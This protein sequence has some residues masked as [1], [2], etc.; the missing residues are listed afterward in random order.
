MTKSNKN[1]NKKNSTTT[2]TNTTTN[3]N[4]NKNT[5]KTRSRA[6][7]KRLK[8]YNIH[9]RRDSKGRILWEDFKS[10]STQHH[11][12]I[13]PDRRW[14]G[15]TRTITQND[16]QKFRDHLESALSGKERPVSNKKPAD[17]QPATPGLTVPRKEFLMIKGKIP[18]SLLHT[19]DHFPDAI[20]NSLLEIESFESTFGPK[21]TR[22]RPK[23][24]HTDLTSLVTDATRRSGISFFLTSHFFHPKE[25]D[26]SRSFVVSRAEEG[27]G[28]TLSLL[29]TLLLSLSLS[30]SLSLFLSIEE[31]KEEAD[32]NVKVELE[33]KRGPPT[34][35][36]ITAGQS[37]RI[38]QELHKVLDS[39]DVVVQVLDARDPLGTRS[40]WLERFLRV[41]YP[42]K[43]LILLLNKADLVPHS[44]TRAWLALLSQEYPT[45]AFHASLNK[46]FG[47][48]ALIQ[49][50]RQFQQLHS[51]KPQISVG[52][53]GYPNVG[54]S[55]VI[56]TLRHKKVC[57]VAP[58]PGETKVWQ[59]ITLFKRIFLID[60]PGVVTNVDLLHDATTSQRSEWELHASLVL[61]G[62]VRIENLTDPVSYI[63]ALL[64]RVKE[65]YLIN[66][67]EFTPQESERWHQ[68]IAQNP[69]E[70]HLTFLEIHARKT[71][72]LK[73]GGHADL[74]ASARM[75]LNDWLRGKIPYFVPPPSVP[76]VLTPLAGVPTSAPL[77]NSTVCIVA[78]FCV[79]FSRVLTS[80]LL[81][82]PFSSS[83]LISPPLTSSLL[84]LSS[85]HFISPHLTSSHFISPSLPSSLPYTVFSHLIAA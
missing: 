48:G 82:P 53:V 17:P 13:Q 60:C 85:S 41:Q 8:I 47:K 5:L 18:Y 42:H 2:T 49:V 29:S 56:N 24:L 54:K 63:P 79:L 80:P 50:L 1:N 26:L 46:P 77:P 23:L 35:W 36:A 57:S 55:S 30:L 58:I 4:N 83:H 70:S 67:Y 16:L 81:S 20:N 64:A 14:F 39:S 22:K 19:R 9:P 68:S 27:R 12:R 37:N 52:F 69:D 28:H 40:P 38:H 7:E 45:L 32:R 25:V 72:R 84:I 71:G 66:M 31:Y 76:A 51:E 34:E 33:W 10:K 61:K 65:T 3:N 78:V 62:V 6:T 43:H 74:A 15:P 59:Y 75:I 21:Q 11:A 73:K 44:V